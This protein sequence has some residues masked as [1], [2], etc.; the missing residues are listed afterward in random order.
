M[1]IELSS[2]AFAHGGEI[3]LLH[4]CE[5]KDLSPALEWRHLPRETVKL[6]LIVDDPDAPDPKAPKMTWV[7]WILY[8]LPVT[9]SGLPEAVKT[10]ALP[11]GTREGI[12]DWRRT[13]YGGPCPPIGRHR[14][15][16]K[17]YALDVALGDLRLPTKAAVEK[18]M[19]GHVLASAELMGTYEKRRR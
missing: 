1:S 12:N 16:F 14:Y 9:S 3:P 19:Q 6:V 10:A 18:A 8:D 4:T 7:H 2:P 17:L 13:G 15:F 5:G 11:Q